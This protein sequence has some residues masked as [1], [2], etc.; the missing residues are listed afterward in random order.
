VEKIKFALSDTETVDFFVL[1]QTRIGGTDYI[2]VTDMEDG[3]GD[4]LILKDL[5]GPEDAEAIYEILQTV[6]SNMMNAR[7]HL[8]NGMDEAGIWED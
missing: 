2:L 6:H 1:E 4:A 8:K 5:S 3:D 7:G